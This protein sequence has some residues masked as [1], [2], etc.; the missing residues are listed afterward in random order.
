MNSS[1][2]ESPAL[3]RLEQ[4]LK[5]DPAN[6]NLLADAID[7]SLALGKPDIAR[8]HADSALALRRDDPF[9]AYRHGNVLI[10]E[11]KLDEAAAV[12]EALSAR[13]ADPSVAHNLAFVYF[14]QGRHQQA[15]SVLEPLVASSE[16]TPLVV[17]LYLRVLHHLREI[18]QAVEMAQRH[19][20]RCAADADF[21]AVASLL[22]FDGDQPQL[23][24]RYSDAALASGRRL[25]EAVVVAGSLALARDD[26]PAAARLFG[27]ALSIAP[28]DGRSWSGL[29][30]ASLLQGDL[31]AA[32]DQ[33]ERAVF[34]MPGHIGSWHA[35]GWCRI[36]RRELALAR[37]CFEKT[38]ALD[39]NF[40]ESHGGLAVVNAL[41]GRVA[42]A[43]DEVKLALRLDP[44]GLSAKY[45][46]MVM[47]GDAADPERF[48]RLALRILATRTG[49]LGTSLK[50]SVARRAR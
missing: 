25:L 34:H 44:Q 24:Q 17:T 6:P 39:R 50:E 19:A 11:G 23:A 45:A 21:L 35:L 16:V 18:K 37:E 47:S 14:R 13:M 46:Q 36:L 32:A 38:L 41:D 2:V 42:E 43:Q 9:V 49:P 29:G 7:L 22:C 20:A 26:G 4:H 40:G 1:S 12:F 10:A 30:M 15:R 31:D 33:L 5:L 28:A 27:E 8:K 3:Q 48:K